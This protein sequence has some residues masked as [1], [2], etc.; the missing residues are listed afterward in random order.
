LNAAKGLVQRSAD[1][2][3]NGAIGLLLGNH[4]DWRRVLPVERATQRAD[5]CARF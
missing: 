3:G 2:P 4:W 5:L 1:T